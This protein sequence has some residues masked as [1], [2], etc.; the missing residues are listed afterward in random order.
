MLSE[1]ER[2]LRRER[3]LQQAES[4]ARHQEEE[5]KCAQ[6][7]IEKK[8]SKKNAKMVSTSAVQPEQ[9]PNAA[10]DLSVAS[11]RRKLKSGEHP[12]VDQWES[13]KPVLQDPTPERAPVTKA[14]PKPRSPRMVLQ[15]CLSKV[16]PGF[17]IAIGSSNEKGV[18]VAPTDDWGALKMALL[19]AKL[20]KKT[21]GV[22]QLL[23]LHQALVNESTLKYNTKKEELIHCLTHLMEHLR[24]D[25]THL[26]LEDPIQHVGAKALAP[27]LS[28]TS[29]AY[30]DLFG[31]I[32]P[33]A[34]V[35]EGPVHEWLAA[36][37]ASGVMNTDVWDNVV[38]SRAS[39]MLLVQQFYRIAKGLEPLNMAPN[40]LTGLTTLLV[41][42]SD[43]RDAL[44]EQMES[45]VKAKASNG[46]EL[47][48]N[49]LLQPLLARAAFTTLQH[50]SEMWRN[51]LKSDISG[52]PLSVYE[53]DRA[54]QDTV[55]RVLNSTR[56]SQQSAMRAASTALQR[57]TLRNK[58]VVMQWLGQ[59]A[60]L[61]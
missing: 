31:S 49:A 26:V 40:S 16:F 9:E 29:N 47:E 18:L 25:I 23:D 7:A 30:E 17:Q 28:A 12:L 34:V 46:K 3:F 53:R 15:S 20:W 22:K 57:A 48:S 19:Q 32:D 38:T 56:Q 44:V 6:D 54:K 2:K 60:D 50:G 1:E 51:Q 24:N 13:R 43:I 33:R 21:N 61:K 45:E 14:A 11:K 52:F 4:R 8:E 55:R 58:A 5:R 37:E 59:I 27:W 42:S 10:R 36:I 35:L 39:G 41:H